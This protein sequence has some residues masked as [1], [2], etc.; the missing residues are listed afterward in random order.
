MRL[1][2]SGEAVPGGS[3]GDLYIR[4]HV[5]PHKVFTQEGDSLRM[6]LVVPL[7]DI[8][9]GATHNIETLDGNVAVKI[10][11]GTHYTEV[12]RVKGKGVPSARNARRGDL[13]IDLDVVMPR[14]LNS[15]QKKLLKELR[16][17]GL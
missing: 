14:K 11:A 17:S 1:T 3:A 10:P 8:L 15:K 5:R 7:S 16:E 2:G 12:L 13:L 9:L 4:M 6:K